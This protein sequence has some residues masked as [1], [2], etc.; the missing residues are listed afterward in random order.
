M[1]S[2]RW[3]CTD[4]ENTG[5][6]LGSNQATPEQRPQICCLNQIVLL[7]R[8]RSACKRMAIGDRS[9]R[10]VNG[11]THQNINGVMAHISKLQRPDQRVKTR[12]EVVMFQLLQPW[13]DRVGDIALITHKIHLS[14]R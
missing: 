5:Q 1:Y 10:N 14:I 2:E 11:W 4:S 9:M 3:R 13:V 8:A 7:R 6:V 12:Q